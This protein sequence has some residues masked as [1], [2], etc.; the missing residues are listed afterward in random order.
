MNIHGDPPRSLMKLKR[1]DAS[2]SVPSQPPRF[3]AFALQGRVTVTA[4]PLASGDVGQR[5]VNF[6]SPLA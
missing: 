1:F 4:S 6:S 5:S 2:K 3:P